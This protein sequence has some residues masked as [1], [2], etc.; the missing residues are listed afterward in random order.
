ME[1]LA[2]AHRDRG[3]VVLAL[4]VDREGAPVVRTFVGR[5]RLTFEVGLDPDQAVARRYRVWA[6]PSTFILSRKGLLLFS[7]QGAREWD[8]ADGNA[9]FQELLA[10]DPESRRQ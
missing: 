10:R 1:R 3:L 9:F 5:H 4:S 7:A 2:R 6:L 8:S